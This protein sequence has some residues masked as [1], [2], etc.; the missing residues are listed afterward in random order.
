VLN[1]DSAAAIGPRSQRHSNTSR[2]INRPR[3]RVGHGFRIS[4]SHNI[5]LSPFHFSPINR[6]V[7][8][9][10]KSRRVKSENIVSRKEKRNCRIL[11]YTRARV[12]YSAHRI[13]NAI[14][15]VVI[16]IVVIYKIELVM[17]CKPHCKCVKINK[18]G[19]YVKTCI[20]MI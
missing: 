18:N 19:F 2:V 11:L 16:I 5:F 4:I 9:G 20:P 14:K 15:S 6:G 3:A 10:A 12:V 8:N 13:S 1:N 17:V 7:F